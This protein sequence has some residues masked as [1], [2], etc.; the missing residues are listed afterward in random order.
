MGLMRCVILDDYQDVAGEYADWGSI[1]ELELTSLRDHIAD[2]DELVAR[3]AGVEI[4]VAMRE[5]TSFPAEVL[6]RLPDLRLL[7]T[8]GMRNASI[9]LAAA[10]R[11][12]ITVCGTG[13]GGNPTAELTWALILGSVRHLRVAT[14]DRAGRWQG[15][16]GADLQGA[17]L[18]LIGLG[19]IGQS[20]ARIGQAFGMDVAAWS[21]HLT[22]ERTAAAGVRR[23]SSLADLMAVSDVVSVHLVLSR[24]TRGI[25]GANAI[26]AMKPTAY[27]VN[28]SRAGLVDMP[29]LT[30]AL[31]AGAIAGAG[32][33]VYDEEP[34]PPD[35]PL[36][37]LTCVLGT[38]HLGY[39]SES[40]YRRYFADAV[41]DVVA[42]RA[43]APVR[44]LTGG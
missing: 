10:S 21:P 14:I 37:T 40:N 3:L 27:F 43:G 18:G 44:V 16:V 17:T 31:A 28:T 5:R 9:D 39:V 1:P 11:L 34:L 35:H 32:L 33:D 20:V 38:P 4:V 2:D 25:V 26:A 8:T 6:E 30:Q 29:A 22:D 36:R 12:G 42:W 13:A 23:A 15:T 19:K 7:V 24:S 41:E